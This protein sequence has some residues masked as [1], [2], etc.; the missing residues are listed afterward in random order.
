M[1]IQAKE[2]IKEV[3][4]KASRQ[5]AMPFVAPDVDVLLKSLIQSLQQSFIPILN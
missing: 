2:S 3:E 1:A 5:A 4:N